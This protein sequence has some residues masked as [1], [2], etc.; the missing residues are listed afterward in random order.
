MTACP[1]GALLNRLAIA[2]DGTLYVA[3]AAADGGLERSLNPAFGPG[4]TFETITRG[5]N[6]GAKLY[7]LWEAD[8]ILWSVDTAGTRLMTYADTLTAAPAPVLP[9]DG[10]SAVGRLVDHTVRNVTLDWETLDGATGYEWECS[11]DDDFTADSATLGDSTSASSVRLPA[12]EPAITYHWRVRASSPAL[13]PWSE[14]RSFTT[15]MD[16]EPITLR[17]ESPVVGATGVPVKP[18][19]EWTAVISAEAYELLVATDADMDNPVIARTGEKA[20]SGNAWQCDVDLDYATTYYWKVRAVN[21]STSSAWSTTG[22][23]TTEDAP[24][25]QETPP[26]TPAPTMNHEVPVIG[27]VAEIPAPAQIE[28]IPTPAPSVN[29]AIMPDL[30]ELQGVPD[31]IIYLIGGLVGTIILALIVVLV[32]L[33][34][35]KRVM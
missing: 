5:L 25:I 29:G 13:S 30:S 31:W 18:V 32:M 14:R 4:P 35:I 20:L 34:K 10:A 21:A 26:E 19:F 24:L 22:I 23:F 15:V 7:G 11:Y 27:S 2:E 28:T 8:H 1:S 17:P 3:N 9:D 33:I 6:S 12:L 16:T